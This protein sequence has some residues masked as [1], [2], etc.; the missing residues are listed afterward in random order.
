MKR[1]R[2]ILSNDSGP[3]HVAASQRTRILGLYGP[4]SPKETGPVSKGPVR[5]LWLD[6]GCTVPC[7]FRSCDAR[8]CMDLLTPEEVL[9]RAEELLAV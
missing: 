6:V 3:I 1:A 9:E 2:F 5:L 7:Y 4:T 8:A